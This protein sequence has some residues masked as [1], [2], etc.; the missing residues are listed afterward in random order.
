MILVDAHLDLSMNALS[1]DRDL[2][3][4]VP[5][6]NRR[7]V[8]MT[9][10]GR[11][12]ATTTFPEM[13][14]GEVA[15]SLATVICRANWPGS[16]ASG[17]ANQEIA[18]ATAQGQL[19][20]YRVLA[21]QGKLRQVRGRADLQAHM[22]AWEEDPASAPLGFILSMEGADPIVD[23]AQ[24]A[25]WWADGLR[26]VGLSHYGPS[27]YAGGTDTEGGLTPRGR[28]LLAA[29]RAAGMIVDLTHLADQAFWET[30]EVFDGPV[31][32]S[33]NNCRAL[34][35]G[36]RQFSDE[37]LRAL[38]ARGGVVGG[39]LDAWMLYPGWVKGETQPEVV[40]LDALVDHLAHICELAG[41]AEHV[42]IGSDLD[43]G[44]GTEQTPRDVKTITDLQKV[45]GLLSAR[46]FSDD[47]VAR[48]MHG[49][50]L[51]FFAQ[52]LPA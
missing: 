46:G 41:N 6:L 23:P 17:V 42:G 26:V 49:N 3:L 28:R 33:H 34:V 35:P 39:A 45:P 19:A 30:L 10:R 1:W 37:Q 9:Q 47:D 16:P 51:R 29:M 52:H 14:R 20:Y 25:S 21:S 13:R 24:V 11:G 31:L 48:V 44:Y 43:G 50:W 18:Y 22:A 40:G 4:E 5:E 8:G 36:G 15:L 7:E 32:A 2:E 38:I 27:A 12:H